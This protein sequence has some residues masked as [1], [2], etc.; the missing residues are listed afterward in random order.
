MLA[1]LLST[2]RVELSKQE[3]KPELEHRLEEATQ[4]ARERRWQTRTTL[5]L[6]ALTYVA[7]LM[8]ALSLAVWG[9]AKQQEWALGALMTILGSSLGYLVGRKT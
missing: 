6:L 1:E 3:S 7:L 8:L 9:D 4:D 5:R 2:Y